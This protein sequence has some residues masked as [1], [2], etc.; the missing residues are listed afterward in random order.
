[1]ARIRTYDA[2]IDRIRPDDRGYTAQENA[3]R[4]I[5]FATQDQVSALR[6][7]GRLAAQNIRAQYSADRV[8]DSLL[9][10]PEPRSSG[11]GGGSAGGGGGSRG[12]GAAGPREAARGAAALADAMGGPQRP[13]QLA[14]TPPYVKPPFRSYMGGPDNPLARLEGV[15]Q[16]DPVTG[17][18]GYVP[19]GEQLPPIRPG[20][21]TQEGGKD[22]IG[23][24]DYE[25]FMNPGGQGFVSRAI[26]TIGEWWGAVTGNGQATADFAVPDTSN[27]QGIDYVPPFGTD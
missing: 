10:P 22:V 17:R 8:I 2:P 25:Q 3:A 27:N 19:E 20:D 24:R 6:E 13:G 1:M 12:G 15:S 21:L 26:N 14:A 4:R 18:Y 5:Q 9:N 23:Q 7:G 16:F 11:G